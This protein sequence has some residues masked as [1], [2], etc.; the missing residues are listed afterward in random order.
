MAGI[1]FMVAWGLIDFGEMRHILTSSK[2]ET[3]VL[4]VAFF[5]ALFLELEFA[6]F[7]GV[8]L[9]LVFYLERVSTPRIVIRTPVARL[10]KHAFSSD[11]DLPQCPQLRILRIDGS[12]FFGSVNHVQKT[13]DRIRSESP[14][15]KHLAIVAQGINFV[16]LQGGDAPTESEWRSPLSHRRQAGPL[17]LTGTLWL[18]RRHRCTQCLPI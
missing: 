18:P 11:P 16:D 7:A 9:S 15:Q 17:E 1:L 8:L 4:G 14:A 10:H 3:A 12:L 5:G 2:R 13:F 6:I